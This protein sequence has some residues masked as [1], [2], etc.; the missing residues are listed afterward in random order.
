M[1]CNT[2][3][4]VPFYWHVFILGP[5]FVLEL[6]T[7]WLLK[8]PSFTLSVMFLFGPEWTELPDFDVF[9]SF[10][11]VADDSSWLC[12]SPSLTSTSLPGLTP[13]AVFLPCYFGVLEIM[14]PWTWNVGLSWSD[15]LRCRLFTSESCL[16]Y[17][18]NWS[19][20]DCFSLWNRIFY[21]LKLLC[22]LILGALLSHSTLTKT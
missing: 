20:N 7:V 15:R 12:C 19:W 8:G 6:L 10:P 3:Y 18:V 22:L 13:V 21:Q 5:L 17:L 1:V 9:G 4:V 14:H 11:V 16:P 2:S